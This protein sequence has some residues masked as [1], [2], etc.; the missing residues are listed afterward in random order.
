MPVLHPATVPQGTWARNLSF[1]HGHGQKAMPFRDVALDFDL[2]ACHHCRKAKESS[3]LLFSNGHDFSIRGRTQPGSS[4]HHNK[5]PGW[6]KPGGTHQL[7]QSIACIWLHGV[8]S[9][10]V[11][12]GTEFLS[13]WYICK[14]KEGVFL[15]LKYVISNSGFCITVGKVVCH[16]TGGTH[17]V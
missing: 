11:V 4:A 3:D 6:R 5:E 15:W 2:Q 14:T 8:F 7:F 1:M 17:W 10:S 13:C 16:L 12:Q 9:V